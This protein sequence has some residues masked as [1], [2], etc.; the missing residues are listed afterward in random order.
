MKRRTP[1]ALSVARKPPPEK[2]SAKGGCFG[3]AGGKADRRSTLHSSMRSFVAVPI[4]GE[5]SGDSWV[6]TAFVPSRVSLRQCLISPRGERATGL[7]GGKEGNEPEHDL[8]G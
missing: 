3:G 2:A 1:R 7:L 5:L 6:M 4:A 8:R